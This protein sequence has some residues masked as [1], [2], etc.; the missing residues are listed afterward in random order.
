MNS[1]EQIKKTNIFKSLFKMILLL[2]PSLYFIKDNNKYKMIKRIYEAK[3]KENNTHD[4][5]KT[6]PFLDKIIKKNYKLFFIF[7]LPYIIAILSCSLIIKDETVKSGDTLYESSISIGGFFS[8]KYGKSSRVIQYEKAKIVACLFTLGLAMG[9]SIFLSIV[10]KTGF[11]AI[12]YTEKLKKL[13]DK[14]FPPSDEIKE[15]FVFYSPVGCLVDVT[16][17]QASIIATT[18]S[19]W[20]SMNMKLDH[21]SFLEDPENGTMVLFIPR[22]DLPKK[23]VY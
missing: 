6:S 13:M 22:F 11:G 4:N 23:L 15:R 20:N 7:L 17:Q 9:I 12:V 18:S 8:S 10:L 16:G 2:F 3:E 21:S 19:I 5:E 1:S 14:S